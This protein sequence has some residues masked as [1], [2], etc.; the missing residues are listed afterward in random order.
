MPF[1]PQKV[2]FAM[3]NIASYYK[4]GSNPF[5]SEFEVTEK[6]FRLL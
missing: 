6:V 1:L 5:V 4:A 2:C 3:K